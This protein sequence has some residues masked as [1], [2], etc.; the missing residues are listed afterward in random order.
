MTLLLQD[1]LT[2]HSQTPANWFYSRLH[3]RLT[4]PPARRRGC[5]CGIYV[6]AVL[7]ATGWA[8]PG[9]RTQRLLAGSAPADRTDLRRWQPTGD[10]VQYPAV[11][12]SLVLQERPEHSPTGISNCLGELAI[13]DHPC[14]VQVLDGD[15]LVLANQS[16]TE[17]MQ[18]VETLVRDLG[19][20]SGYQEPGLGQA[21]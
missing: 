3:V 10:N 17:L 4:S 11:Q 16:S 21:M 9:P 8:C 15:P 1:G 18:E 12:F 6:P 5:F 19:V 7:S 20:Q 2:L 14:H 13:L